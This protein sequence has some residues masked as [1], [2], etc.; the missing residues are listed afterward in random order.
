MNSN[1]GINKRWGDFLLKMHSTQL[2]YLT[3]AENQTKARHV[4]TGDYHASLSRVLMQAGC[5]KLINVYP[6]I[7]RDVAKR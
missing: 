7:E 6:F 2:V 5:Q 3:I 4:Q 1:Y